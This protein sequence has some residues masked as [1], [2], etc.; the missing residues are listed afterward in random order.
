M[1]IGETKKPGMITSTMQKVVA[2]SARGEWITANTDAR[3]T[4]VTTELYGP[5]T[6]VD[7][8][9]HWLAVPAGA[10]RVLIQ[11]KT[12]RAV[13]AVGTSPS[14][15]LVGGWLTSL[16]TPDTNPASATAGEVRFARLDA[17][18]LGATGQ[19]LTF[20]A[21]PTT[22]NNLYDSVY[23][24]SIM[25]PDVTSKIGYDLCGANWLGVIVTVAS[26]TTAS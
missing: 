1:A 15:A 3:N 24:Y 20:N 4:Q 25:L 9:F 14:V 13:T 21:T 18:T 16:G 8:S 22:S 11:A 23:W 6:I 10:T 12:L 17:A 7:S 26:A 2:G 5:S 19:A